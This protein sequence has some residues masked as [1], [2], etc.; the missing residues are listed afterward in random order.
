MINKILNRTPLDE[1][2]SKFTLERG[3]KESLNDYRDR[4][5]TAMQ[6]IYRE[7][8][9]FYENS[10]DYITEY[11]GKNI[12]LIEPKDGTIFPRI[13]ITCAKIYV[14]T[15]FNS[16]N[17]EHQVEIK[18]IKFL[19]DLKEWLESLNLFNV[20]VL[21]ENDDWKYLYTKNLMQIDS[22]RSK[23]K[24]QLTNAATQLPE[25][26]V[27]DL[28]SND[29][30]V[31]EFIGGDD[32]AINDPSQYVITEDDVLIKYNETNTTVNYEYMNYPLTL[33]W[34]PFSYVYINDEDLDYLVLDKCKYDDN[35]DKNKILNQYGAKLYN[36]ILQKHNTYWGE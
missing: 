15:Q 23:Y 30:I 16:D 34:L 36:K 7:D 22:L 2:G 17:Y 31:K 29:G 10:F 1:I 8:K 6:N 11:R 12:F 13:L 9:Y 18:D 19:I 32:I 26:L 5:Y 25:Q 14:S 3:K 24:F 27:I 20:K 21:Q 4:V 35:T 33:K 28:I